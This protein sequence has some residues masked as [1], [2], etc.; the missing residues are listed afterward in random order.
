[1]VIALATALVLMVADEHTDAHK[2]VTSK[3]EYNKDVFPL[4]RDHCA[5]CHVKGGPAP[6]SLMTYDDTVPWAGIDPRRANRGPHAAMAGRSNQPPVK[7]GYPISSRESMR[8]SSGH[9]AGPPKAIPRQSCRHRF[10]NFHSA[11]AKMLAIIT[12]GVLGPD[13]FREMAAVLKASAGG[14]PDRSGDAPPRPHPG[15]LALPA[16][17]WENSLAYRPASTWTEPAIRRR[18]SSLNLTA[19]NS[20]GF[21]VLSRTQAVPLTLFKLLEVRIRGL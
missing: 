8:S 21:A 5:S 11:D 17:R 12:P 13:Y 16:L 6:M 14:P 19:G 2:P 7:G 15:T 3:Y 4:L 10:D 1:V 20:S 18:I 9:P